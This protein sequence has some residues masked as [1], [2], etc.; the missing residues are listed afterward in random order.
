MDYYSCPVK[1]CTPTYK[2][3]NIKDKVA[4]CVPFPRPVHSLH[5]RCICTP[6]F[7]VFYH[8]VSGC[9]VGCE[10]Q[11]QVDKSVEWMRMVEQ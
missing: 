11:T 7:F 3:N 4:L 5:R 8:E 1:D 9:I 2:S 10:I 6:P